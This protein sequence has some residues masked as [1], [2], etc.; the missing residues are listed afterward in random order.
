MHLRA[1]RLAQVIRDNVTWRVTQ[2]DIA[3]NHKLLRAFLGYRGKLSRGGFA[4]D[5]YLRLDARLRG[6]LFG[7]EATRAERV[8][9]AYREA[10]KTKKLCSHLMYLRKRSRRARDPRP[11]CR[12]GGIAG[13]SSILRGLPCF[14]SEQRS[15]RYFR[16]R[17]DAS[18]SGVRSPV[19]RLSRSSPRIGP[20]ALH[21]A[22]RTARW[23][24]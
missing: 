19:G 8:Q 2:Q 20:T 10:G 6:Q 4:A 24:T 15:G 11:S 3:A 7:M 18:S 22:A 13:E 21:R 5:V 16:K 14:A 17:C 12:R 23:R 9:A 1:P